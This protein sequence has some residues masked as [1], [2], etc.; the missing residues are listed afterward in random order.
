[1]YNFVYYYVWLMLYVT[2]EQEWFGYLELSIENEYSHACMIFVV[3]SFVQVA[4]IS[5]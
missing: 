2:L 1:M 5:T 4:C 3:V